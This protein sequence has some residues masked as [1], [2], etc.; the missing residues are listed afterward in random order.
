MG[1]CRFGDNCKF[2]HPDSADTAQQER[3]A[4]KEKK[5]L[6]KYIKANDEECNICL[7]KVLKNGR[8]FGVLDGCDHCFCLNCIRNWRSTYD[9]R[10]SKLHFRTCPLCRQNSYLV[11][12]SD[13]FVRSG[14]DKEDLIDQYK[15][16]L[17]DIPCKHFNKGKG[18]CPFK[19]S[20]NYA[21]KLANGDRY[22]YPWMDDRRFTTD[23]EWIEDE[24][25]TLAERMGMI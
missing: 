6:E 13:F 24:E 25:P 11:I 18:D 19:N 16:T 15:E 7:M 3:Q 20:C 10:V 22:E 17:H 21:H 23:G 9:K 12:P 5:D 4:L 14:P 2:I 8:K 1:N